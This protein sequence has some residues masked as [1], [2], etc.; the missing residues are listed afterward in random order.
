MVFGQ[1]RDQNHR[2][3]DILDFGPLRR[4]QNQFFILSL[5]FYTFQPEF[6]TF[7]CVFLYFCSNVGCKSI[8]NTRKSIKPAQK[9]IKTQ[10]KYKN[11]GF[12]PPAWSKIWG[13]QNP[14][15]FDTASPENHGFYTFPC[16][17]ILFLYFFYTF[18]YFFILFLRFFIHLPQK[19]QKTCIKV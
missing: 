13:V 19:V 18:L 10:G 4:S 14:M 15:I 1:A 8:K 12:A 7:P 5:C 3:L 11:Q 17:F 2:I 16:V 6:Y 9:S